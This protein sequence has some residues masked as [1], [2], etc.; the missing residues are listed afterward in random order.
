VGII[1][2]H[3]EDRIFVLEKNRDSI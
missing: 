2:D 3:R 1:R